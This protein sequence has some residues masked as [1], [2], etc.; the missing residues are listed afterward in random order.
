[1]SEANTWLF[2]SRKITPNL[3]LGRQS[4][5]YL[6]KLRC[7]WGTWVCLVFPKSNGASKWSTAASFGIRTRNQNC[8]FV[9]CDNMG[10]LSKHILTK[11]LC[12]YRC[13]HR[14]AQNR[15]IS[16][17]ALLFLW[18]TDILT[19]LIII[20]G[21]GTGV[22]T[23]KK[24]MWDAVIGEV[25]NFDVACEINRLQYTIKGKTEAHIEVSTVEFQ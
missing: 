16:R 17:F 15:W 12:R 20:S 2:C 13:E 25:Q 11:A 8:G 5:M 6:R 18:N 22:L 4:A 21:Q 1:M 23:F 14:C 7:C 19:Y 24:E 3:C 10:I 9:W